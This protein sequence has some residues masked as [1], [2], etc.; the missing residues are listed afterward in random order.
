[1]VRSALAGR[2]PAANQMI[3]EPGSIP[4]V[5][6]DSVEVSVSARLSRVVLLSG[7]QGVDPSLRPADPVLTGPR[8]TGR[9]TIPFGAYRVSGP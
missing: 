5:P 1:M 8:P 7:G 9:M 2:V 3:I 4:I 6:G